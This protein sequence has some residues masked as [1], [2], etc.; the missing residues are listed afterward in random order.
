MS[1]LS[2]E[3]TAEA[4]QDL[5]DLIGA[6]GSLGGRL[7]LSFKFHVFHL[8]MVSILVPTFILTTV[9][10]LYGCLQLCPASFQ[11]LPHSPVRSQKLPTSKPTQ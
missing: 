4:P 11:P 3:M 5:I 2:S 1:I 6:A 9:E 7:H 8:G 10:M